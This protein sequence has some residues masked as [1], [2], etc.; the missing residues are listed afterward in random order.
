MEK[1]LINQAVKNAVGQESCENTS[2]QEAEKT[3]PAAL[4]AREFEDFLASIV[5]GVIQN[6]VDVRAGKLKPDEAS[7]RDDATVRTLAQILMGEHERIRLMPAPGTPK[8]GPELVG[9]MKA[10]LPALFR[11]LPQGVDAGNPRA[12]MVHASRVFLRE[13]YTMLKAA[14]AEAASLRRNVLKCESNARH[15]FGG[16]AFW[17]TPSTKQKE[18]ADEMRI[19]RPSALRRRVWCRLQ[20]QGGSKTQPRSH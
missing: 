19:L 7:S 11:D 16:S 13:I 18:C 1:T 6:V 3:D 15:L 4:S 12:L 20:Q 5:T 2:V 14:A 17:A 8:P 9:A 10:N